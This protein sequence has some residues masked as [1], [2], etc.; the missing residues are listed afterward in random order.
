V[1]GGSEIYN[2]MM[3]F[4]SRVYLTEI[5]EAFEGDTYFPELDM[6]EFKEVSRERRPGPPQFS[7]VIY[8]K[9]QGL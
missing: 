3:P 1:I 6:K 4:T 5:E 2:L 9:G 7:Y 8:E